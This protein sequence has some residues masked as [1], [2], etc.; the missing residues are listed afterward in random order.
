MLHILSTFLLQFN[1]VLQVWQ[2]A[3]YNRVDEDVYISHPGPLL[4]LWPFA[5][6][7]ASG[8][9]P[10]PN[11][12]LPALATNL[13]LPA[14]VSNLYLPALAPNLCLP[15]LVP[16]LG[17]PTLAQIFV[18]QSWPKFVFTY[19][20]SQCV[21]TDPDRKEF[22]YWSW[23]LNCIYQLWPQPWP[24]IYIYHSRARFYHYHSY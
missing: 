21:L 1:I 23:S 19:P 5:W 16:N 4:G 12:C 18:Y 14:L 17:L 9:D 6:P 10:S 11:L 8:P 2:F 15:T 7:L 20:G 24:P 13:Y 22:I 3:V